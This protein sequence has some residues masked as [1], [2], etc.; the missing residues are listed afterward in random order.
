MKIINQAKGMKAIIIASILISVIACKKEIKDIGL[1]S[2]KI[3]GI[4]AKWELKRCSM[5]D[6]LSLIKE[7]TTMGDFFT[8]KN[9]SKTQPNI[10]FTYANNVGNYTV[11]TANVLMNFFQ[12]P[13]GKW[14][15]DNNDFPTLVTFIPNGGT[16]FSLPLGAT[17]RTVDSVLKFRKPVYCGTELKF[18]YVLEFE[19]K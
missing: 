16:E 17:I 15:F 18:S 13:A 3:D 10:T 4:T 5:V 8:V 12:A 14:S 7:T 6:E 9:S 19:R 1:P 11:D 2:S